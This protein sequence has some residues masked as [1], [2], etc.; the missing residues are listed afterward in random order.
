VKV[1][2]TQHTVEDQAS[3]PADGDPDFTDIGG[4]G[5]HELPPVV[6]KIRYYCRVVKTVSTDVGGAVKTVSGNVELTVY[7][8]M[9]LGWILKEAFTTSGCS[10]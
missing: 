3:A 9:F 6:V 1:N 10:W 4:S 5:N 8:L 2:S 7:R